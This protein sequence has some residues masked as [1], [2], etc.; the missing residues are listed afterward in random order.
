MERKERTI[1]QIQSSEL[2]NYKELAQK[3]MKKYSENIEKMKYATTKVK[4]V[5]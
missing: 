5:Y 4:G 1:D 3:I 2:N